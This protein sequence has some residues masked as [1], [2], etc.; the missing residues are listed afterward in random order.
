MK[1]SSKQTMRFSTAIAL[2][3]F[4]VNASGQIKQPS[5]II[6]VSQVKVISPTSFNKS[7]SPKYLETTKKFITTTTKSVAGTAASSTVTLNRG[8]TEGAAPSQTTVSTPAQTGDYTCVT[9]NV[10][11]RTDYF[12]QPIIS[13]IEFFY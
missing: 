10:N 12:R 2:L 11:E 8:G 13:N 6:N 7:L 3:I 9:R 4:S 5:S 1:Q